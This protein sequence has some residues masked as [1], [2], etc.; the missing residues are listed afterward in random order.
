MF[1][2]VIKLGQ[3][4]SQATRLFV[5]PQAGVFNQSIRSIFSRVI[6]DRLRAKV[7]LKVFEGCQGVRMQHASLTRALLFC[8]GGQW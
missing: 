8:Q 4:G 5:V 1:S 6:D 2:F 3:D 7:G